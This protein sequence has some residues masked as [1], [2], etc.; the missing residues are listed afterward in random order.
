MHDINAWAVEM[1]KTQEMQVTINNLESEIKNLKSM[2]DYLVKDKE[3]LK[4]IISTM[5]EE[6]RNFTRVSKLIALENENARLKEQIATLQQQAKSG[7]T[8]I[9]ST[10]VVATCDSEVQCCIEDVVPVPVLE[11]VEAVETV[12]AVEA[13]EAVKAVEA[14][15]TVKAVEAV[16]AVEGVKA[17]EAE[18]EVTP[19]SNIDDPEP[20]LDVK[21]KKIAGKMYYIDDAKNIY[22]MLEEGAGKCLGFLYKD[23]GRTKVSWN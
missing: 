3:N 9:R 2:N 23:G 21:P 20:K 17:V 1:Q 6:H 4:S 8:A 11:A 5:E 13:V 7:P 10:P 22:E 15:E 16:K 18:K 12:K 19:E 14:V